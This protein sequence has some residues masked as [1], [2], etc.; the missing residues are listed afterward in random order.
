M[1]LSLTRS[2]LAFSPIPLAGSYLVKL[3][4]GGKVATVK[5]LHWPGYV[6]FHSLST[7]KHGW[8]YIGTGQRNHDIGFML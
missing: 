1:S 2:L 3:E 6:A 8:I 4:Q 7:G 5:S